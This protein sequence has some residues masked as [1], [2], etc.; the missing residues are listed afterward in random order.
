MTSRSTMYFV[1]ACA[2]CLAVGVLVGYLPTHQ[3]DTNLQHD[4]NNQDDTLTQVSTINSILNGLYDGVITYGDLKESGDFGIGTFNG[5]DG[6]MVALDG[7]FYQI[8]AD[9][10]SYQVT[11]DM[12]TPFAS[13]LFFDAD[14]EIPVEKGM[15][16]TQLQD[17]LEDS[18]QKK[19]IFYAI[20]MEGTFEYVKTRSVPKQKKPYPPLVEVTANQPIFEFDDVKGAIVGFYCPDY[21]GGLNV[22]GYHLHFITEDRTSGG[23]VLELIIKD[24]ELSVDY[25]SEIRIILPDTE[26]FNSLDLTESKE[27]ELEE[28]EK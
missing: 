7:N 25:T 16:Y 6:E 21:I 15:N 20:E 23:H 3:S 24:A 8:K 27:E 12:I 2:V 22:P 13:V 28:A 10:M 26:E 14:Q 4:V 17:H 18:I 19:N 1:I 9:G 11:D 5:L